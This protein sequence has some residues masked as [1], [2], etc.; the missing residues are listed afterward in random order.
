MAAQFLLGGFFFVCNVA[1]A[2]SLFHLKRRID[3]LEKKPEGKP[4]IVSRP[5]RSAPSPVYEAKESEAG[6]YEWDSDLVG[7]YVA[8]AIREGTYVTDEE[9]RMQRLMWAEEMSK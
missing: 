8:D 2:L 1:F 5:V 9:Q 6:L 7:D 4:L 3:A